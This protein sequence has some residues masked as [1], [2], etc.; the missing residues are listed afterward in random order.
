M[1]KSTQK[2]LQDIALR[3]LD[4][5]YNFFVTFCIF[6]TQKHYDAINTVL[7]DP[8]RLSLSFTIVLIMGQR[9][10][11]YEYIYAHLFWKYFLFTLKRTR[12]TDNHPDIIIMY[13]NIG[14]FI[15]T[16]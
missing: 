5:A 8:F 10:Y 15:K 12:F 6:R 2:V 13:V 9:Y 3:S 11:E 7:V 16:E 14:Q 4:K 1:G